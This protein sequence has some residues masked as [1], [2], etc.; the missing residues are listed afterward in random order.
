MGQGRPDLPAAELKHCAGGA[1][2]MASAGRDRIRAK[3]SGD[4]PS[5][6]ISP[7]R[8][9]RTRGKPAAAQTVGASWPTPH[10]GPATSSPAQPMFAYRADDEW[11]ARITG[12]RSAAYAIT[13]RN[14]A[15]PAATSPPPGQ[16]HQRRPTSSARRAPNG[17]VTAAE[18]SGGGGPQ[19]WTPR[20]ATSGSAWQPHPVRQN[21]STLTSP[22]H[23]VAATPKSATAI[24]ETDP[25]QHRAR[26]RHAR[27]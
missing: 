23:P 7:S 24:T 17:E 20:G 15:A 26:R 11:R 13:R 16:P 12:G 1:R 2:E 9:P 27:S 4:E 5:S 22:G 14:P 6:A 19:R 10:T 3:G 21:A 25:L 18:L 8:L